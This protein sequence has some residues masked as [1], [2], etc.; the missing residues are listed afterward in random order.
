MCHRVQLA[1]T[2]HL[3]HLLGEEV[4]LVNSRHH[5]AVKRVAAP[6]AAVGW[7]L[8][9]THHETGPLIEAIEA[10]DPAR[11]VIGV[12][13]HPENLVGL[14]G[15]AGNVARELFAAFVKAADHS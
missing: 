6:L 13:W 1:P 4:F 10:V 12:Q 14:K 5:Q 7:H 3:R 15:P 9:T 11:W 8:D 2:S